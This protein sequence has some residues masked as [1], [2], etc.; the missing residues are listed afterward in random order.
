LDI[1]ASA[2]LSITLCTPITAGEYIAVEAVE[3]TLR[4]HLE[5]LVTGL[6]VHGEPTERRLVAVAVPHPAL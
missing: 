6:W 4:G 1:K 3:T 2:G 5:G